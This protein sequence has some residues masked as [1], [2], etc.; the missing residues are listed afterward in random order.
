[1]TSSATRREFM[2]RT[3]GLSIAG[4]A[5]PWAIN[6]AAISEKNLGLFV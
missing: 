3:T 6:L 4:A 2:R 1:M 5:T